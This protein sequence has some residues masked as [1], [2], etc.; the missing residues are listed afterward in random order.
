MPTAHCRR[1]SLAP[2]IGRL[3]LQVDEVAAQDGDRLPGKMHAVP[4]HP[5]P[6][7]PRAPG[8][9]VTDELGPTKPRRPE[10]SQRAMSGAGHRVL[11]D[12]HGWIEATADEIGA[13]NITTGGDDQ[14]PRF[15]ASNGVKSRLQSPDLVTAPHLHQKVRHPA[16]RGHHWDARQRRIPVHGADSIRWIRGEVH[17]YP[18]VT[19]SRALQLTGARG[20]S[21]QPTQHMGSGKSCVPTQ[22][23]FSYWGE[24]PKGFHAVLR[25][26]VHEGRL[27]KIH[28]TCN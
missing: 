6:Y 17:L 25:R 2:R 3:R 13:V 14:A 23:N 21:L 18:S 15:Q 5:H 10:R 11:W 7:S 20:E 16:P 12:A 4:V 1:R 26:H 22:V 8:Q 27:R 24:P 28:L 9:L 19:R